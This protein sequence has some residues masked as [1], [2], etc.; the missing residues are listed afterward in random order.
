MI[1]FLLFEAKEQI[2]FNKTKY[3]ST[4]HRNFKDR[5]PEDPMFGGKIQLKVP[6]L[7]TRYL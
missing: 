4:W 7:V 6:N 5:K 3:L 2:Y 1:L